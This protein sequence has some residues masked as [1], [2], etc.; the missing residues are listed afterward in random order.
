MKNI[1]KYYLVI[2]GI[3]LLSTMV[4][5]FLELKVN[6]DT[7]NQGLIDALNT[8]PQGID[9]SNGRFKMPETAED[10][11]PYVNPVSSKVIN[12]TDGSSNSNR[13]VQIVDSGGQVGGIW[14]DPSRN[15][16]VSTDKKQTISMWINLSKSTSLANTNPIYYGDGLAF[17]LQM[18]TENKCHGYHYR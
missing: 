9:L 1:K 3:F 12:T 16:Y 13:V 10:G 6:A 14:G 5:P 11:N 17:V 15:N 8:A 7:V 4:N 18:M 2:I